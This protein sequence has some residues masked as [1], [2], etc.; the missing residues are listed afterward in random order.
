VARIFRFVDILGCELH[1]INDPQDKLPIPEIR[2]VISIGDGRMRFERFKYT[3]HISHSGTD[4]PRTDRNRYV[5]NPTCL[6]R[7]HF[8]SAFML[9]DEVPF[10]IRKRKRF[11]V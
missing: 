9:F 11:A 2:Q 7:Q 3:L 6:V 10:D 8:P 1:T 5:R 4:N